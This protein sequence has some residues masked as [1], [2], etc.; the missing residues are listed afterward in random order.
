MEIL[1][2]WYT[3]KGEFGIGEFKG[4][5]VFYK[6]V[7]DGFDDEIIGYNNIKGLYSVAKRLYYNRNKNLIIY[8][9]D[10]NLFYRTLHHGL[11]MNID[12]DKYKILDLLTFPLSKNKLLVNEKEC[13]NSKFFGGRIKKIEDYLNSDPL[14][15]KDL[16]V[17]NIKYPS[18]N[19]TLEKIVLSVKKNK[20]VL[21]AITQG[22]P[23]DLNISVDG[24]ITDFEVAGRNSVLGE[25]AVFLGCFIVNSYYYYIKYVN[26]AHATYTQTLMKFEGFIN[27]NY[28]VGEV[29]ELNLANFVPKCNEELVVLYLEKI[30]NLFSEYELSDLNKNLA[31]YVAMRFM[32]PV[33]LKK[34]CKK[35]RLFLIGLISQIVWKYNSVDGLI[36]LFKGEK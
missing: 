6:K 21:S 30:K 32:S 8:E 36:N 29:V 25:I 24:K 7:K 31:Y 15:D 27:L 13:V 28:R 12:F 1:N 11:Y 14:F 2:S 23:T 19:K 16:I 26:S 3:N 34:L 5:K 35:D 33:D 20:E 10:N 17:N 4:K 22:D 18:F 9:F